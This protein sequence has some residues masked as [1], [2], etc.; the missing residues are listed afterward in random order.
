M[1]CVCSILI[2]FSHSLAFAREGMAPRGTQYMRK[3]IF[4]GYD[5]YNSRSQRIAFDK[6]SGNNN[7]YYNKKGQIYMR[8]FNDRVIYNPNAA[9]IGE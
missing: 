2:I 6:K 8:S 1:I 5:Y 9:G 4:G 3:N 7:H